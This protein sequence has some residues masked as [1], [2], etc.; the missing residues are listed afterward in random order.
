MLFCKKCGKEYNKD[1]Y[2]KKKGVCKE[3]NKEKEREYRDGK[4]FINGMLKH[5]KES[6]KKRG[7]KRKRC[8]EY[9]LSEEDIEEMRRLQGNKCEVSGIELEWKTKSPYKASVDRI[10]SNRGYTLD[11]VRLVC[12]IVNCGLNN[13][14][15][16]D[17]VHMCQE[18]AHIA[19]SNSLHC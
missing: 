17:F 16:E 5:C 14:R 10:D 4:G 7:V 9:E 12:W 3:C 13:F 15:M 8:G 1:I 11:N 19:Q 2:K 18:I 6:A